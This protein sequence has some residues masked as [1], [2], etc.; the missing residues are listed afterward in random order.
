MV[1]KK[2]NNEDTNK[3][4]NRRSIRYKFR[5]LFKGPKI[6]YFLRRILN[7]RG[8]QLPKE[9]AA[10]FITNP[11]EANAALGDIFT[12]ITTTQKQSTQ[13]QSTSTS[14]GQ[15]HSK[16]NKNSKKIR[17]PKIRRMQKKSKYNNKVLF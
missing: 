10:K 14:G 3:L 6:P 12:V 17:I 15:K 1:V 7:Y 16:K 4:H 8:A 9:I 13:E 5:N 11:E 2:Y